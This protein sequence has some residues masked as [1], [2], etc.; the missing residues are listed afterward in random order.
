VA[1]WSAL[2]LNSQ[3]CVHQL[4]FKKIMKVVWFID[5]KQEIQIQIQSD[6]QYLVAVKVF[7]V[8]K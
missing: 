6:R 4:A 2:K 5:L 3:K 7:L 8:V 1:D